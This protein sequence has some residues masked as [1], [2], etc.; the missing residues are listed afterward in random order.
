LGLETN[1]KDGHILWEDVYTNKKYDLFIFVYNFNLL[2][3][4]NNEWNSL[5]SQVQQY[6]KMH[7]IN[8]RENINLDKIILLQP[9]PKK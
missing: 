4:Y 8:K 5:Q 3:E 7:E 1:S 9:I 2:N 6:S